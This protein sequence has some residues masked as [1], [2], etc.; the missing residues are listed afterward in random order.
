MSVGKETK[1]FRSRKTVIVRRVGFT[2]TSIFHVLFSITAIGY[3][4][5]N[6]VLVLLSSAAL[7]APADGKA[8]DFYPQV[9]MGMYHL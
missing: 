2:P 4:P 6:T 5:F 3:F 8:I 7:S 9:Y 1:R